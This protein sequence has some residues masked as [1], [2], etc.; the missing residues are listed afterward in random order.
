VT[1]TQYL[2]V[3]TIPGLDTTTAAV[4]VPKDSAAS[5][6][7]K[8]PLVY[9][10]RLNVWQGAAFGTIG[11][12]YS[13]GAFGGGTTACNIQVR[14]ILVLPT[15]GSADNFVGSAYV[16]QAVAKISGTAWPTTGN[17]VYQDPNPASATFGQYTTTFTAGWIAAGVVAVTA[18]SSDA[19][20][21]IQR[22]QSFPMVPPAK[23]PQGFIMEAIGIGRQSAAGTT[24]QK[25]PACPAVFANDSI[26]QSLDGSGVTNDQSAGGRCK[27][28]LGRSIYSSTSG[29]GP[30]IVQYQYSSTGDWLTDW[31]QLCH[32]MRNVCLVSSS[33]AEGKIYG[34]G[35]S[36]YFQDNFSIDAATGSFDYSQYE[37][38]F[39]FLQVMDQRIHSAT[40]PNTFTP[41]IECAFSFNYAQ[42]VNASAYV[43]SG[44]VMV[45]T[46]AA[47]AANTGYTACVP[48]TAPAGYTSHGFTQVPRYLTE[49]QVISGAGL[50]DISLQKSWARGNG[51]SFNR[52]SITAQ[53]T[54]TGAYS[55]TGVTC[56]LK[57]YRV[58]G[59]LNR[60]I[61]V[62]L[63]LVGTT[64]VGAIT[65]T[66]WSYIYTAPP[67]GWVDETIGENFTTTINY[68]FSGA[69]GSKNLG[70][71]SYPTAC[72]TYPWPALLMTNSHSSSIGL[73]GN[74][75]D[76]TNPLTAPV[77]TATPTVTL[78][79]VGI[80][81]Q[82]QIDVVLA[83]TYS[84]EI[85]RK[86]GTWT[87]SAY[88]NP[89]LALRRSTDNLWIAG[90]TGY[91]Y[92]HQQFFM[93][94]GSLIASGVNTQTWRW[95][96]QLRN[97]GPSTFD[98]AAFVIVVG[99]CVSYESGV[100]PYYTDRFDLAAITVPV[101]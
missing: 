55:I 21:I 13:D 80:D 58:D 72:G 40:I 10:P 100:R 27:Q 17:Q 37:V 38:W 26:Y 14:P 1:V 69:S 68:T 73:L 64:T 70:G 3:V 51:S 5:F 97:V 20:G 11:Q 31:L 91:N 77:V 99:S 35:V 98:L 42:I 45:C 15:F 101:T 57:I 6:S 32:H 83:A 12:A 36:Y 76:P 50:R 93:M 71:S 75:I 41:P 4:G 2:D 9:N 18:A 88:A 30:L 74:T 52:M 25:S 29:A 60:T 92:F 63:G 33:I 19:V 89:K 90:S 79:T 7:D 66:G 62:T 34:Q 24:Y 82:V 59:S 28:Y 54:T 86:A 95:T 61:T 96:V 53:G 56:D 43:P 84:T 22:Y 85:N 81:T 46:P 94:D 48:A 44:C 16:Y 23:T 78:S 39:S 65:Y 8:A 87:G 47:A 49:Y 67:G